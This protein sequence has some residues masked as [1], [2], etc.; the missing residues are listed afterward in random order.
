MEE[1]VEICSGGRKFLMAR[2]QIT[3]KEFERVTGIAFGDRKKA[4]GNEDPELRPVNCV[5]FYHCLVY[6]NLRSIQENLEP[7][8][9]I[10]GSVRPAKWGKIPRLKN[11]ENW[12]SVSC[13]FESSG[14]RLPVKAE[15]EYAAG[16][17]S[18]YKYSGSD[19][20]DE[21]GWYYG[22]SS[23]RAHQ[24]ALKKPNEYGLFDMSGNVNEWGWDKRHD[25]RRITFGGGFGQWDF[26]CEILN[27]GWYSETSI[28]DVLG[29]RVVKNVS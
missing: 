22:N 15:W 23:G 10:S 2:T 28:Y 29:F 5:S 19:N 17:S 18:G 24:V 16:A 6:C 13:N 26:C 4:F 3:R 21:V 25:D 27:P 20:L 1:F 12:H 7:C 11:D 14:Y 8:Y 9:T